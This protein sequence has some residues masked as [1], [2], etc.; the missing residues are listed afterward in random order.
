M[1]ELIAGGAGFEKI[2]A[3]GSFSFLAGLIDSVAGGGG[4]IQLPALLAIFPDIP[5][6]FLLGTNKLASSCGTALATVRF[7]RE[8]EMR[9]RDVL[10]MAAG[11][12]TAAVFGALIAVNVPNRWL[13]PFVIALLSVVLIYTLTNRSLGEKERKTSFPPA[14]ERRL[15]LCAALAI[16]LY[17]GF[18][19]P[20]TG[21]FLI[22]AMIFIYG[23]DFVHASASSKVVNLATNIGALILFFSAGTVIVPLG[24]TMAL[25]NMA[26][27]FFGVKLAIL[28][29]SKFI[30]ILFLA[31]VFGLL[32]KQAIDFFPIFISN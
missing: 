32:S 19:G 13:R 8:V 1:A 30:R 25:F 16:G 28:K 23:V 15:G 27:A 31:I 6:V 9:W 11:A 7:S 12:L 18:F 3:M 22:L 29:G 24:L 10:P 17:D 21:N 2:L 5:I 20:G 14:V 26:G 4:L